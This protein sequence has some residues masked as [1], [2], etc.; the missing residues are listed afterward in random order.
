MKQIVRLSDTQGWDRFAS[1]PLLPV[2]KAGCV[3]TP[4]RKEQAHSNVSAS[5]LYHALLGARNSN[6]RGDRVSNLGHD[7]DCA[8]GTAVHST[9]SPQVFPE[10]RMPRFGRL[11]FVLSIEYNVLK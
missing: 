3:R 2:Q 8:G 9:E 7:C 10:M 11:F 1:C 5:H 4:P 6:R